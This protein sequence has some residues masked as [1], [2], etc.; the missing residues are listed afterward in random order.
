VN[1]EVIKPGN[2]N[3]RAS[4]NGSTLPYYI[5]PTPQT[6]GTVTAK[7]L[8]YAMFKRKWQVLGV[9]AVVVLSILV[10]GI[11]RPKIYRSNAKVLI[12]PG[13]AEVQLSAGEQR[14]ITFPVSAS[15]EMVNSEMEILRSKELMRQ[16]IARMEDQGQPIFGA[17][18]TMVLPE[19]I[20]AL[21]GMIKVTPAPDSN[22]I[23]V[24]LF[25]RNA[26]AGQ[27]IL[28]ALTEAYLARHA[29]LHGNDGASEFF[30]A[31]KATLRE[32]LDKSE[33]SLSEFV[34]R[35]G[36]VI[37]EDQ[38]RWALKDGMR[39]QEALGI[40]KAKI[41][42]LERRV[43][44]LTQQMRTTPEQVAFQ[45]EHVNPT[46][47]GLAAQL[48][49]LE[50]KRAALLQG[51]KEDDRLVQDVD[52][53]IAMLKERITTDG[54]KSSVIGTT[55]F[56]IN[57]VRQDL[58]RRLL[59]S[60]LNL[61]DLRARAE[62]LEKQIESQSEEG[63]TRAIE[64]RQKS[65]E[66]TRLQAE[67]QAAREAYQLYERKEEEARIS[68]ALDKER[69]LN[70]GILDGPSTPLEP[71][72]AMN[73]L[74]IIAALIA[75]TGLGVGSALGIEFFN[76]NFKFEE[77]VEQYLDMP[78]FAVIPEMTDVADLQRTA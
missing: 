19:Q 3:G 39:G 1:P 34:D 17:D 51:Y 58:Q 25:A 32:R 71:V 30:E 78:V 73:P 65:I 29:Q 28:G 21:Q 50:S 61:D 13:R 56:G 62:R 6:D 68:E 55:R 69:F 54:T 52:G 22:V 14:E 57:P 74:M 8:L 64:L 37:P 38:I 72:N 46:A 11:L 31:Q 75:G 45:I 9:I 43:A 67:V 36:V 42:G 33:H 2:G 10:S 7:L 63:V 76:R 26:Q 15:T 66:F 24:D 35:E 4:G 47:L 18:T 12:R 41:R 53:E 27:A 5:D 44:T 20:A 77:Q 70:V 60:Q 59:N 49:K 23:A 48:A 40:H 16:V